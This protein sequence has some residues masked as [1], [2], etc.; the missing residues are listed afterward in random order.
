MET[1]F[2]VT[3]NRLNIR[4]QPA[5]EG[6][7]VGQ[8][9]RRT[10]VERITGGP[11]DLWW[12]VRVAAATREG[13][14][15]RRYLETVDAPTKTMP[16]G[17]N[18]TLWDAS[19]AALTP[20][21]R[22]KLGDKD[23][24][25]G[26]IDC[27]GWVAEITIGAFK[28]VN[29]SAAPEVV[30]DQYDHAA[31]RTH[32]DGQITGVEARTGSALHGEDVTVANLREGMLIGCNNGD[33]K[34]ERNDPPRRYGI[35][36]IVQV[37]KNPATGVLHVSQSSSGG[38]G[39]TLEP[40]DGW[41]GKLR[42]RGLMKD[43]RVHAVDP[44]LMADPH[45]DFYARMTTAPAPVAD[46]PRPATVPAVPV[47]SQRPAFSG[48][49]A[50]TYQMA[51]ILAEFES[52]EAS[53]QEMKRCH[54]NHLWVRIHG[55]GYVGDAPS[56]NIDRQQ[57]LI[58]AARQAG[59]AVAGWGWCQGLDPAADAQLALKALQQFGIEDYVADIEQGVNSAQWTEG[60]V[61]SFVNLVRPHVK[62]LAV[63]SHGFIEYQKPS[64]FNS[65]APFVDCF[66]PQAYWYSD[67]P[68]RKMLNFVHASEA[69]YP[70]G[71]PNY[72]AKLCYDRWTHL[73]GRPI[74]L[75][76]HT[77]PEGDFTRAEAEIQ[78]QAFL[79]SFTPP[80]G[81]VGLNYW[82]WGATNEAMRDMLA[83]KPGAF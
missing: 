67:K 53:V 68:N 28:A 72:Y 48:R 82:H 25:K 24:G 4:Q 56:S 16:P 51:D 40:L 80:H 42:T 2:L 12:Y 7:I 14:V 52:I 74:V 63:S 6:A 75:S 49:G 35:D 66:N 50:Y 62:G 26:T 9:T 5:L 27:S 33:Y 20:K 70:L 19:R 37:V 47:A 46:A 11:D 73:Y 64:I 65:C 30:F 55:R 38:R 21:V 59:I 83:S 8:I 18:T 43:N 15:S 57:E 54:L 17:A 29:L 1:N 71:K 22:Y 10:R 81:L 32:S 39:V 13:F 36:H 60:E 34:W 31:L 61:L 69:D 3:A 78:L 45:S 23:S 41:L 44:F 79:N 77:A 76:G 58:D